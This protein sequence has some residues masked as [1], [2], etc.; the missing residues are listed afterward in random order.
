MSGATI[1]AAEVKKLRDATGAGMMEC[2]RALSESGGDIEKA[3]EWLRVRGAAKADKVAGR[4]AAEG[5]IAAAVAGGCAALVEVNCE[6][7]FVSRSPEVGKF[8]EMVA[9]A[10]A[11]SGKAPSDLGALPTPS[12]ETAEAARQN[13]VMR[14]GENIVLSRGKVLPGGSAFYV[15]SDNRLGTIAALAGG[16]EALGRDVCMHIA[17]MN[18][19]FGGEED[20]PAAFIKSEREVFAAQA[21]ESGKPPEVAEKMAAGRMK[22]RL[23]EVCLLHQ[24]FVKDGDK[25]VG[26]LLEE[27]GA[28]LSGFVRM[29]VGA[30]DEHEE[31][32]GGVEGVEGAGE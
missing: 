5:R 26:K 11:Q 12:G 3:R 25:T 7:D 31:G 14:V 23:A 6:T 29:A 30:E 24:P 2:K 16:S 8:A 32:A 18:P 13:L 1:T 19:R 21:A 17:A 27:N 28:S 10:L 20:V 22:K 15:H 9:L 4:A